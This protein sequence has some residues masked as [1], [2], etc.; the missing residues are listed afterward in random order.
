MRLSDNTR[1]CI[2]LTVMMLVIATLMALTARLALRRVM[3]PAVATVDVTATLKAHQQR[4]AMRIAQ[5]RSDDERQRALRQAGAFGARLEH[6]VGQL[7]AECRCVLLVREAVVA[8]EV[9][10]MSA[11]LA[12]LINDEPQ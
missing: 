3:P 6:A 2:A 9:P 12:A 8:G 1:I 11:R 7:G 10:D 4:S 5:A